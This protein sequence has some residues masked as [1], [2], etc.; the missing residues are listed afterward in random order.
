MR[1]KLLCVALVIAMCLTMSGCVMMTVGITVKEDGSGVAAATFGFQKDAYEEMMSSLEDSFGESEGESEADELEEFEYNGVTYLG[2]HESI[3]FESVD[4]LNEYFSAES[5][6]SSEQYYQGSVGTAGLNFS[7]NDDK[8]FNL[9]L[10]TAETEVDDSEMVEMT[11]EMLQSMIMQFEVTFPTA[12]RQLEGGTDGITI[13]G[14]TVT[15]DFLKIGNVTDKRVFTTCTGTPQIPDVPIPTPPKDNIGQLY[16]DYDGVGILYDDYNDSEYIGYYVIKDDKYGI[17]DLE[18][19]IVVEPKYDN[20]YNDADY[21][22]IHIILGDKHGYI[23]ITG[24]EI[25]PV[26]YDDISE[27]AP[28][29]VVAVSIDG[30]GDALLATTGEVVVPFGKYFISTYAFDYKPLLGTTLWEVREDNVCGVIDSKGN[31][32]LPLEYDYVSLEDAEYIVVE[33]NDL[34]GMTDLRGTIVIPVLYADFNRFYNDNLDRYEYALRNEDDNYVRAVNGEL[35]TYIPNKIDSSRVSLTKQSIICDGE[36]VAGLEVY[37]ID[38]S[39]YFKL[40]DIAMLMNNTGSQF[41]VYWNSDIGE[42]ECVRG[43][44]YASVGGELMFESDRSASAIWSYSHIRVDGYGKSVSMANIGGNNFIKLRDL[45]ELFD[46]IVDWDAD[47]STVIIKSL[48]PMDISWQPDAVVTV[49]GV[50][51]ATPE[52]YIIGQGLYMRITDFGV[53]LEST[54]KEFSYK[55]GNMKSGKYERQGDEYRAEDYSSDANWALQYMES[56]TDSCPA[57]VGEKI[58]YNVRDLCNRV[59]LI[60]E[61]PSVDDGHVVLNLKTSK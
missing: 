55:Y 26:E 12:I 9:V 10:V 54:P 47:T 32:I 5:L 49:D 60:M 42:V 41:S 28:D 36:R 33:K 14:N 38:G 24:K 34:Y 52:L 7:Q 27:V 45:G 20:V 57:L 51:K 2:Q 4:E 19:N 35:C 21:G 48:E 39:N 18:G 61:L 46:F 16:K 11:E 17:A 22:L 6:Q 56:W 30:R 58:F 8:S 53:L 23:D 3:E 1:K 13:K 40:R 43:E 44:S 31:I 29:G 15:I 59:G 50:V 25:I 37:N